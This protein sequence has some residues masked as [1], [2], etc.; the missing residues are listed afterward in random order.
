MALKAL[1]NKDFRHRLLKLHLWGK[2][3]LVRPHLG[4]VKLRIYER[5]RGSALSS[6]LA[7]LPFKAKFYILHLFTRIS[8]RP[9]IDRMA[10]LS[11]AHLG[12]IL[13]STFYIYLQRAVGSYFR[14]S[15]LTTLIAL[16][17]Y[18]YFSSDQPRPCSRTEVMLLWHLNQ[19]PS[20]KFEAG[21]RWLFRFLS[22][23]CL[24][25][26]QNKIWISAQMGFSHWFAPLSQEISH[27][28]QKSR[29]IADVKCTS[30]PCDPLYYSYQS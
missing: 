5:I 4:K 18:G 22:E 1:Q 30:P 27:R 21:G 6:I 19:G 23:E 29:Q 16:T 2:H 24:I 9:R 17:N 10:G 14:C 28:T 12:P 25:V 26:I 8:A 20:P 13:D 7:W 3:C 11:S 15:L